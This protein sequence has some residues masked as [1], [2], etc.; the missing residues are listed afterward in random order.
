MATS[1]AAIA[2]AVARARREVCGYFEEHGAF[3]P[4]HAVPFDPARRLH[5]KRLEQ[6]LGRGIVKQTMEGRYWVDRAAYRLDEERRAAA[7]KRMAVVL[8]LGLVL[9][10]AIIAV[11]SV[12]R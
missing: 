10:L 12:W 6:L 3:D 9:G 7:A 8:A 11:V 5:Q 4:E 1:A 2:V